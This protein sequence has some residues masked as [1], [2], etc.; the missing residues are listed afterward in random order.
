M[1]SS[2]WDQRYSGTEPIW[3]DPNR[4]LVQE[5]ERLARGRAIDLACGQGRNALWL[6]QRGWDVTGVDFSR[7][8]LE[9]G[10]HAAQE[11]GL[12]VEWIEAD[13]VDYLPDARAFDLVVIFYLQVRRQ[14]RAAIV[15]AAAAAVAPGGTFLLVGHDAANIDRGHGGPQNPAVLYS[16]EDIVSDLDAS[17]LQLERAEQVRRPVQTPEGERVAL[18]VLVR[19]RRARR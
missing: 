5:T 7:V 14:A 2:A 3:S 4:F 15:K 13:L 12:Q 10:R 11:R 6:A 17:G 16:A 8:G 9:K 1:N 19:A 18:D